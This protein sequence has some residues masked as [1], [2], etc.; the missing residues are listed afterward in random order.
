MAKSFV[1]VNPTVIIGLGGTGKDIIMRVR[2]LIVEHYGALEN[3][4][5]VSFLSIDTDDAPS[6]VNERFLNQDISLKPEEKLILDTAHIPPILEHLA[7]YPYLSE[8]FPPELA[9]I[10]DL[11]S[12]AKQIRALGRLSYFLGYHGVKEAAVGKV[13]AVTDRD[14]A[15]FMLE[16]YGLNVD[17]GV[18]VFVVASLCGGTGSGMFLDLAMSLK[19]WFKYDSLTGEVNG[20]FMLPGAFT[21]VSDRIKANAYA[22]LKELNHYMGMGR[23]EGVRFNA[24]YTSNPLD[25]VDELGPPFTFCYLVGDQNKV[26]DSARVTDLQ[27]MIAQKIALEFTSNFARY[28]KSNR[29]NLEGVW[30]VTPRDAF[31]QPQ[32]F[33]S[34]GLSSLRFP[35]DRVQTALAARLGHELMAHLRNDRG[36]TRGNAAQLEQILAKQKWVETSAKA[37]FHEALLQAGSGKS[38]SDVLETWIEKVDADALDKTA[39]LTQNLKNLDS[40]LWGHHKEMRDK[41]RGAG[42]PKR[43]GEHAKTVFDNMTALGARTEEELARLVAEVTNDPARGP[44]YA[45]WLIDELI[46]T[47]NGYRETYLGTQK[48][49]LEE[50]VKDK[51]LHDY[52]ARFD[53][54]AEDMWLQVTLQRKGKLDEAKTGFLDLLKK[55]H[56]TLLEAKARE[57]GAWMFGKV[58]ERLAEWRV[59]VEKA[60]HLVGLMKGELQAIEKAVVAEILSL[61]Y[62]NTHYLFDAEDVGAFY[63]ERFEE[64]DAEKKALRALTQAV[65]KAHGGNLLAW[66]ALQFDSERAEVVEAVMAAAGPVFNEGPQRFKLSETTVVE[67]FFAKYPDRKKQEAV[68]HNLYNHSNPFIHMDGKQV[69]HKF[70]MTTV[71]RVVGLTGADQA[72]PSREVAEMVKV[73]GAACHLS[74]TATKPNPDRHTLVFMQEFGAFPLRVIKGLEGYKAY[75]QHFLDQHLHITKAHGVFADLFPPDEAKLAEAQRG[76]TLGLALG[77]LTVD[78]HDGRTVVYHYQDAAGLSDTLVLG[79]EEQ[80]GVSALVAHDDARVRLLSA[81]DTLGKEA[82]SVDRR[83]TLYD[84]LIRYAKTM[85]ATLGTR[86][87]RYQA[88]RAHLGDFIKTHLMDDRPGAAAAA[89]SA[90]ASQQAV[91]DAT[92]RYESLFAHFWV[93]K[94]IDAAE[95]TALVQTAASLGLNAEQA[96]AI[97][98][99]IQGG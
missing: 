91:A 92:A 63:A 55:H 45:I 72:Q 61:N 11:K 58:L 78:A 19:H 31:G 83:R 22:C 16:R 84:A 96:K 60:D 44:R 21:G 36:E 69:A 4:P 89:P 38:F 14:R 98:A 30:Q 64:P 97:E 49:L 67:R 18:N 53:T 76:L 3:L 1:G 9:G 62:A 27:E 34:F 23:A 43:W 35:A 51:D 68:L 15:K 40:I 48:V 80:E 6:G 28:S 65:L 20:L 42:E 39:Q 85:E 77:L 88:Q 94:V 41:T 99:K 75:Y 74:P 73:L 79:A 5:V 7:Q 13:K 87:P 10:K 93:D 86:H 82:V 70:T 47:F 26:V 50:G 81:I 54:T 90:P 12:G 71:Q 17:T 29:S 95:R 33:I 57:V 8:W 25:K 32:N 52:L 46:A 56:L 37:H 59:K 2:R 66:G 24:Q